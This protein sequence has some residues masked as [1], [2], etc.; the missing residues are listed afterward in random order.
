MPVLDGSNI[1]ARIVQWGMIFTSA[2]FEDCCAHTTVPIFRLF[3]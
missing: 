1:A 3:A 2:C